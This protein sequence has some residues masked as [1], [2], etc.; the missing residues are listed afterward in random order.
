M[1]RLR[2]NMCALDEFGGLDFDIE[3]EL[4]GSREQAL[5]AVCKALPNHVW[6]RWRDLETGAN[7]RNQDVFP[8]SAE[9]WD[10]DKRG[11]KRYVDSGARVEDKY[12]PA[13]LYTNRVRP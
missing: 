11:T 6:Y 9:D 5:A 8:W 12:G 4:F 7:G 3:V 10:E 1:T 13:P 2:V